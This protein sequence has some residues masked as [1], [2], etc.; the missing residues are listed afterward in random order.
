MLIEQLKEIS[1]PTYQ[2]EAIIRYLIDHPEI[3]DKATASDIAYLTYTS[4]STVV[5]L[6]KKLGM[7]GYP[8]FKIQW[9]KEQMMIQSEKNIDT[10]LDLIEK[11]ESMNSVSS[12]MSKVYNKVTYETNNQLDKMELSKAV[13][14]IKGSDVVNI[15]GTASNYEVAKQACYNFSTLGHISQAFHS[16]NIQYINNVAKKGNEKIVSVVISHN[17][18][19]QEII[20]TCKNLRKAGFPIIAI[21]GNKDSEIAELANCTLTMYSKG[22][23]F[24]LSNLT[25]RISL[26]YIFD[27]IYAAL[28]SQDIDFQKSNALYSFTSEL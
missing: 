2:E 12:T 16:N 10:S 15:Y 19:N 23:V 5:R 22:N 6:C 21:V 8:D 11:N 24:S 7:K 17:G 26:T 9:I 28:L 1:N 25:Y 4:A 3:V 27:V 18:K 13:S 20:R 14:M